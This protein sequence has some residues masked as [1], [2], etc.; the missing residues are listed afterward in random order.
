MGTDEF[1]SCSQLAGSANVRGAHL[2]RNAPALD[3]RPNPHGGIAASSPLESAANQR[4]RLPPRDSSPD[5]RLSYVQLTRS[6]TRRIRLFAELR[7]SS[8]RSRARGE[9]AG[10]RFVRLRARAHGTKSRARSR[11][12]SLRIFRRKMAARLSAPITRRRR[13][14]RRSRPAVAFAIS[15]TTTLIFPRNR[16]IRA[17][18]SPP[19]SRSRRA[20]ARMAAS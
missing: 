16:R 4:Y 6:S 3:D 14:G 8:H 18:T 12:K 11:A 17:T 1:P 10:D 9:A 13:I 2:C 7:R 20:S 19:R 15:I 5:C